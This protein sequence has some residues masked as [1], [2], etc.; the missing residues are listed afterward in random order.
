[1]K[2]NIAILIAFSAMIFWGIFLV[3]DKLLHNS[4]EMGTRLAQSYATEEENRISV[5]EMLLTLGSSYIEEKIASDASDQELQQW[6][7]DYLN[8]LNNILHT[9]VIDPYAVVNQK[10]IG[11][12]PWVGDSTYDYQKTE[13]Y[14]K[15]IAAE[16]AIIFT[17]CYTDVIT[18][19]QLITLA[20]K[21]PDSEN[22]LA[23]DIF[24]DNFHIHK[25]K[26]SMPDGSSYFLYDGNGQ[27]MYI[28]SEL[29]LSDDKVQTYAQ[30]LLAEIEKGEF[31]SYNA[32]LK[33]MNGKQRGVYY[34]I[35][36]NGWLSVITIPIDQILMGETDSI[37]LILVSICAALFIAVL[38]VMLKTYQGERQQKRTSDIIRI[39][40]DSY[41]SIYRIN[42]VSET[43]ETIKGAKDVLPQLGRSGDYSLLIRVIKNLVDHKTYEEFEQ[44]FSIENIRR[45]VHD[46]IYD[47]GGDYQRKFGNVYRWVNIRLIFNKSLDTNEVLLCFRE[48]ETEKNTDS[49]SRSFF[50]KQHWNPQEKPRMIKQCFSAVSPTIC[51]PL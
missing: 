43:Y 1:M 29:D 24:L 9:E 45:L 27:L 26:A 15:A 35:M 51:V 46:G 31:S 50:W 14:Q 38:T 49:F 6:L 23:F 16:G 21:L 44:S 33:D 28:A 18:G 7:A 36:D 37:M 22:V 13:W 8:H 41:Y 17:D 12:T 2:L 32:T 4:Y 47:F 42:Y 11:A 48:I 25:N 40:G 3:R 10:I 39:L 5:Y 30:Q 19:R 20:K 34:H